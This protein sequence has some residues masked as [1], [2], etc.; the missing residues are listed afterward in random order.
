MKSRVEHMTSQPAPARAVAEREAGPSRRQ[1]AAGL[2]GWIAKSPRMQQQKATLQ[3][4]FGPAVQW[5]EAP[6][7]KVNRTGMPDQLKAGVET[8]SGTSMDDVR[9]HYD[10]DKPAQL[11]ALAYAQGDEIH[12]GPGQEQHLPHDA[13]HAVQQM[14]GRVR[15]SAAAA[16]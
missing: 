15:A 16:R 4:L 11:N 12:L 5:E 8:L 2:A 13:W 1:T 9:V 7:P 10:S 6:A 14:Q 3:A